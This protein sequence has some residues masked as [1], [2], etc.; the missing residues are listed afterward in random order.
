MRRACVS[1]WCAIRG[2]QRGAPDVGFAWGR[3]AVIRTSE[4][5]VRREV[6]GL[7]FVYMV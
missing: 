3:R 7:T 5:E 1:G 2:V 4:L 6:V